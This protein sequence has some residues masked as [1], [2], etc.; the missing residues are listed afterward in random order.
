M[1]YLELKNSID[2][3]DWGSTSRPGGV[4]GGDLAAYRTLNDLCRVGLQGI[5][6]TSSIS[7]S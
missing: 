4:L 7:N 2:C 6:L 3:Q 5:L 1:S